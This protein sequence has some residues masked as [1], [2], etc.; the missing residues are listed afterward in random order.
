MNINWTD[1]A[2]S[3]LD[4]IRRYYDDQGSPNGG[5]VVLLS[6]VSVAAAIGEMPQRGRP[7]RVAGTRELVVPHTPFIIAY[8]PTEPRPDILAVIHSA[9]LWPERL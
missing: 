9:R 4:S 1:R 8:R 6:I 3:D 5:R 2:L 7:G